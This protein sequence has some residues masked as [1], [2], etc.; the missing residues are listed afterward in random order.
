[1]PRLLKAAVLAAAALALAGCQKDFTAV[2]LTSTGSL[3]QFTTKKPTSIN[4]T[5][6]VTL[7]GG[8]SGDNV[9]R[10]AAQPGTNTLYCVTAKGYLCTLN[11]SSGAAALVSTTPFTQS[12]GSGNNSVVLSNPVLSFDPVGGDLRVITVDYNLLVNPLT[13]ALDRQATKLAFD[14]SDTNNNQSPVLAGIAYQNP[15]S[16]AA[17]TTLYALDITTSSLLRVG[18]Q[19]VGSGDSSINGGALHTIGKLNTGLG[20]NTGFAIAPSD[21]TAYASL[22]NSSAPTLYTIDLKGGSAAS[23]GTIG[24]GT[25]TINSLVIN[26]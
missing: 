14:G 20:N 16:H 22:Q 6:S 17:N 8:V 7:S 15:V 11:V 5:V 2:A 13:G 12:L 26:P 21:G 9:I 1:M 24:D 23:I 25:L 3:V 10:M 19:N 4:S 18:D